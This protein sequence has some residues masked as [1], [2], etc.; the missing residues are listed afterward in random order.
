MYSFNHDEIIIRII[1]LANETIDAASSHSFESVDVKVKI[2]IMYFLKYWIMK[3]KYSEMSSKNH[4]DAKSLIDKI[5]LLLNKDSNFVR[6]LDGLTGGV[7]G[8]P[9]YT[10]ANAS[11]SLNILKIIDRLTTKMVDL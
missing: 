1:I 11:S 4:V 9:A 3:E 2:L 7:N 8:D 6:I 5:N 10:R